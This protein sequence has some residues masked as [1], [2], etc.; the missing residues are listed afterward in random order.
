MAEVKV[1]EGRGG[2]G[3]V[4]PFMV[5]VNGEVLRNTRGVGR[6]FKTSAAAAVAGAKEVERRRAH[7]TSEKP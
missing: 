5:E 7:P 2:W 1:L 3:E 4:L 6:R